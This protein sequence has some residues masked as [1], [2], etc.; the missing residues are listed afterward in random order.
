[1]ESKKGKKRHG[2]K[3]HEHSPLEESLKNKE[4]WE[5][6]EVIISRQENPIG[7]LAQA[8]SET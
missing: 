1:M 8:F 5:E 7:G 4:A 6:L 3:D 2:P